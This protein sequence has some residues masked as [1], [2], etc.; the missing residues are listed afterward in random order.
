MRPLLFHA[1]RRSSSDRPRRVLHLEFNDLEHRLRPCVG[2]TTGYPQIG[3][4]EEAPDI[5]GASSF[6]NNTRSTSQSRNATVLRAAFFG[7]VVAHKECCEP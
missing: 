1:S 4:N 7:R 6:R 5:S 2:Q 3:L